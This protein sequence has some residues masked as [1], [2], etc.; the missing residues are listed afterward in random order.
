MS[1][2][3]ALVYEGQEGQRW[4]LLDIL[5]GAPEG[6]GLDGAIDIAGA[7]LDQL[8]FDDAADFGTSEDGDGARDR[9]MAGP[10]SIGGVEMMLPLDDP[11]S[12]VCSSS[13]KSRRRS[14][15][16]VKPP[17]LLADPN[18]SLTSRTNRVLRGRELDARMSVRVS[19]APQELLC[20]GEVPHRDLI[21]V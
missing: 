3:A 4:E 14:R 11:G 17:L 20:S 16:I 13:R 5:R 1:A 21:P 6:M 7:V 9:G 2:A 8:G 18:W 19:P 12:A 10:I 15:L